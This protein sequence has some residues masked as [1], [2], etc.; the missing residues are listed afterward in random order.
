MFSVFP[1]HILTTA[2]LFSFLPSLL[3]CIFTHVRFHS[4]DL[5]FIY[6]QLEVF[7]NGNI[8]ASCN[9]SLGSREDLYI[10]MGSQ[11]N[12]TIIIK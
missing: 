2:V 3:C 1:L 4:L 7:L 12:K 9:I 5:K 6:E 8:K 10:Q 11:E